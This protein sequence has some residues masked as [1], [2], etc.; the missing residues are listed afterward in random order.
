MSSDNT[1]EPSIVINGVAL[2][3]GQA[4]TVRVAVESFAA[5]LSAGSLG[6]D[7]AGEA[8]TKAYQQRINEIRALMFGT[9]QRRA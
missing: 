8:I 7:E 2:T 9:S 5:D 3:E 1:R 4:M 6:A